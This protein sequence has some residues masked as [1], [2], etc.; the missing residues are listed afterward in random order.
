MDVVSIAD[1]DGQEGGFYV[2]E[3]VARLTDF[4]MIMLNKFYA[5]TNAIVYR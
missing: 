3:L 4:V 5:N 1:V 2:D